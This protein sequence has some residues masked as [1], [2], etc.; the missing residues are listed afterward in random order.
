[1]I[2][3]SAGARQLRREIE[4]AT[5]SSPISAPATVAQALKKS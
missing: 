1:M 5:K 4:M 2:V 3:L